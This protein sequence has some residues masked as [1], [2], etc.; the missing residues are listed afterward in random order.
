MNKDLEEEISKEELEVVLNSFMQ[1][2]SPGP[3]RWNSLGF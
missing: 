2:K 1:A 3:D